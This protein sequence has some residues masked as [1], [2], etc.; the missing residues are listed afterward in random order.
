MIKYENAKQLKNALPSRDDLL[1]PKLKGAIANRVKS[2][3]P[4]NFLVNDIIE[5][6]I[7]IDGK[8]KYA[9]YLFGILPD[10]SKT[11]VI[12]EN[13]DVYYDIRVP[14]GVKTQSFEGDITFMLSKAGLSPDNID[15]VYKYPFHGHWKEKQ[16]F[17]RL[18][19]YAHYNYKKSLSLI[20]NETNYETS[21]NDQS[22]YYRKVSREYKFNPAGQNIVKSYRVDSSNRIA[23]TKYVL[24][25]D[26]KNFLPYEVKADDANCLKKENLIMC[27]WDIEAYTKKD[28]RD[29]FVYTDRPERD[30]VFMICLTFNWY[31]SPK[32]IYDITITNMPC[33]NKPG[34]NTILCKTQDELFTAMGVVLG[35]IKPEFLTG[36]NDGG[37]DF[38]MLFNRM[39]KDQHMDW[40][41]EISCI[42]LTESSL[43]YIIKGR[44]TE[45]KIKISADMYI[46]REV[47]KVPGMIVFDTQM[48]FQKLFPTAEGKSLDFFLSR[49]RLPLK[50]EMAISYMFKLL[51]VLYET[52]A[53]MGYKDPK[54]P[55]MDLEEFINKA[56]KLGC[57]NDIIEKLRELDDVREYCRV[58]ARRC[59]ELCCV[60]TV[61][62][63]TREKSNMSFTSLHDG[64]YRA[65]GMKVRN[66]AM[67][68]G[69]DRDI[70]FNTIGNHVRKVR[71]YPGGFVFPPKKGLKK[72]TQAE[73]IKMKL[74]GELPDWVE[75]LENLDV[76][77]IYNEATAKEVLISN[78]MEAL[79]D[80]WLELMTVIN[81][82]RPATG[83][84]FSSLYPSLIR[85][86]NF[87]PDK[88]IKDP[89]I[90]AEMDP[91]D[92]M[93]VEF[94]YEKYVNSSGDEFITTKA[95]GWFVR[96][97]NDPSKMGLYVT[98]LG[99]LYDR[100]SKIKKVMLT[101]E[102][103]VKFMKAHGNEEMTMSELIEIADEKV[104]EAEA[105][106]NLKSSHKRTRA[107]AEFKLFDVKSNRDYFMKNINTK[108]NKLL[109]DTEFEVS[110][111]NSKQLALK[112]FMNT[113][114][115]EAGNQIS[116]FYELLVSG[117]ICNRGQYNI[118]LVDTKV[119]ELECGVNYGD[120]DSVYVSSPHKVFAESDRAY[121]VGDIER[122]EYWTRL[123][124]ITMDNIDEVKVVVNNMLA[125]DNGSPYLKVA[126]EEVLW[127]VY[128]AAKKKYFGIP[129]ENII[130]KSLWYAMDLSVDE[131][132]KELFLRGMDAKKRGSSGFL[133][134]CCYT[135]WRE[136]MDIRYLSDSMTTTIKHIDQI[137]A[138]DWSDR[139]ELFIKRS[140][141][142]K[143]VNGGPGNVSVLT[144][145]KRMKERKI[146]TP[147]VG[148]RF[149]YILVEPLG[150]M[151][152][153]RGR[154]RTHKIGE[155][156]EFPEALNDGHKIN[157][158]Y[159]MMNEIVGQFARTIVYHDMFNVPDAKGEITDKYSITMAKH[160]LE[161]YYKNHYYNRM[162]V[163]TEYKK[164][165]REANKSLMDKCSE[166]FDGSST[167]LKCV[168][169]AFTGSEK[170]G[171]DFN[172]EMRK[173]IDTYIT[174]QTKKMSKSHDLT[175]SKYLHKRD[176]NID[177]LKRVFNKSPKGVV[178]I[179]KRYYTQMRD[180]A[181]SKMIS[182]LIRFGNIC[183]KLRGTVKDIIESGFDINSDKISM[184]DIDDR[185]IYVIQQMNEA[186]IDV[187][188]YS[189]CIEDDRLFVERI[190]NIINLKLGASIPSK[191]EKHSFASSL[192]E[193]MKTQATDDMFDIDGV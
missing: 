147:E 13:I 7:G 177:A 62:G 133:K 153:L 162:Q 58:D 150:V 68:R 78:S 188:A 19:Y 104:K 163:P 49:C 64:L 87:S 53:K 66:L 89:A 60:R 41:R 1:N 74:M 55:L 40:K 47:F 27:G 8:H 118:K 12:L 110:V 73:K 172:I 108:Y 84:D 157:M 11:T 160:Y 21:S 168:N 22:C 161:K 182:H 119:R 120:T 146:P 159:Y 128:L 48:I 169:V 140:R 156:M 70:V 38:P 186:L 59:P 85:T 34:V 174:S 107:Y 44:H 137:M 88:C 145:I 80:R 106:P 25:V 173:A 152:D 181:Y 18:H 82:D 127:P 111:L 26:V 31:H 6:H 138:A 72:F 148:D 75:R 4:I 171:I 77:P 9:M 36:F 122:E 158:D 2:K 92:I 184:D 167:I 117:S 46:D 116:P 102:S 143:P 183:S 130:Q 71:N 61:I 54:H 126:Y 29:G 114:Y 136:L 39:S 57:S 42:P 144:F 30:S 124:D 56:G 23:N 151:Y 67:S 95:K 125:E 134:E 176:T 185:D 15:V 52:E 142:K 43:K 141:Y 91:N 93:P 164:T 86:Y 50:N 37:Y 170:N 178:E 105:N 132:S 179:R 45:R 112:L 113:F 166:V 76:R 65:D 175:M 10:G 94:D 99:D 165:F 100:R 101:L 190:D 14:A 20:I 191:K 90:A 180:D 5:N 192:Q 149:S 96:H 83:L 16:P 32:S 3:R 28:Q 69:Y 98:I 63:D 193:F 135:L 81:Y 155:L 115:G 17:L 187:I 51:D 129:H 79:I 33:T 103:S 97:H 154:K 131:F 121:A 189:K 24:R 139:S 35:N 123:V 109:H